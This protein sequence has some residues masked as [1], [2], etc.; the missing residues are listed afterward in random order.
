MVALIKERSYPIVRDGKVYDVHQTAR[1]LKTMARVGGGATAAT[2]TSQATAAQQALNAFLT[3]APKKYYAILGTVA[4]GNPGGPS[5][6]VIWQ[7]QIPII[8]AFCTAIDYEVTMPVTYTV[9]TSSTMVVSPFAPYSSMS[10]QFTLGGAPP[11]PLTELTPWYLD[12]FNQRNDFDTHFFGLGGGT[13]APFINAGAVVN[14]TTGILDQGAQPDNWGYVPGATVST[15]QSYAGQF[16]LRIQLQRKRHLLWGAVPF[17]DPENRPNNITQINALLGNNPE[18]NLFLPNVVGTGSAVLNGAATIKATYELAY[19]DLLPPGMQA[20]PQPA[21]G[22]GLQMVPASPSI[23][24]AASLFPITHRTAMIYTD[25]HHIL[26][27]GVAGTNFLPLRADYFGLWDDQ[28]Q[29][30]SRW[31]FDAQN[32]TLNTY[33]DNFHRTWRRYPI[34]GQ[35]TAD[36]DSGQFPEIPSVTPYDGLMTPDQSYA[37][38]FGV[39]VTPAMTTVLRIPS[40]VPP[41]QVHTP[42]CTRSAS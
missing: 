12:Q 19:I 16:K 33:F 17:G 23:S 32:N 9:G 40:L 10:M 29:Q 24:T 5:A 27:N 8:P 42:G 3:I 25:I 2:P 21:V 1:G 4:S 41:F 38:T 7:Q 13:I 31:N 39:P 28:D 34:V 11:W 15:T 6:N 14:F 22:Y 30:S 20:P 36:F 37:Q 26:V 18:S 35:Y